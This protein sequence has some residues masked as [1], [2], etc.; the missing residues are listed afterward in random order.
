MITVVLINDLIEDR[1]PALADFQ[2]WV[3]QV[4]EMLP[5]KIPAS[6]FEVSIS[7]VDPET[8]A[9]LNE[10]YRHK[11]GP[12]NVLSFVYEATP[13]IEQESLGD[14]VIC[15]DLVESEALNQHKLPVAHWAHLTV[16]GILHLLGYD[17]IVETEA[18]TMESLEVQILQ[19]LGF[20]NPYE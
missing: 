5:E 7:I 17:H 3:N 11:K 6:C 16:H 4:I 10:T 14:L 2:K 12:T 9:Q 13:G 15:A 18:E 20:N 19:T 8:S 1:S